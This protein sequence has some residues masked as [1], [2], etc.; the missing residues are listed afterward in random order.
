TDARVR[1]VHR[2]WD[3]PVLR[4]IS[5]AADIWSSPR[6]CPK[7]GGAR[8]R[9]RFA[10]AATK[11]SD[12]WGN[13]ARFDVAYGRR[14]ARE[15][16]YQTD[17]RLTWFRC[18]IRAGDGRFDALQQISRGRRPNGVCAEDGGSNFGYSRS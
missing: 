8:A 4:S 16:F 10:R 9:G 1:A 7:G 3:G 6:P 2:T 11:R 18:S 15:E 14:A 13:R 17:E 5:S 12:H